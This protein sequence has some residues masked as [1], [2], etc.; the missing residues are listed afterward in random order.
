MSPTAPPAPA[1]LWVALSLALAAAAC[2]DDGPADVAGTYTI[3]L[4]NRENG[5]NL[6]N[7]TVGSASDP[8]AVV[9][10]QDGSD[11]S[12]DVQGLA[13]SALDF[14][15]GSHVFQRDVDGNRLE[16]TIA[17][18]RPQG[19]GACAYTYDATLDGRLSGDNLNGR[20]DY[21]AKTN[22]AAD[23]GALTGCTSYQDF[24]GARP[25]Q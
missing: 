7:W 12:A 6:T 25:P 9:V 21:Q 5:C 14:A 2:S 20:V 24:A 18:T 19:Q 10:T 17:G 4:T 23:C 16:A 1:P 11:A 13:G 15:L 8:V 3:V 22:G